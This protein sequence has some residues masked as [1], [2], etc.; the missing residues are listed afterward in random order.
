MKMK[1]LMQ[2]DIRP[3]REGQYFE[4]VVREFV[5]AVAQME[6]QIVD[7]WY[8]LYGETP[9]ILIAGVAKDI[10]TLRQIMTSKEWE[11]LLDNLLKYVHNFQRK[12]VP[13]RGHFQL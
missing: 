13:D 8:T 10:Q 1:L 3:G 11:E 12:I 4:F 5:P 6:L 2:W 7:A 9:K